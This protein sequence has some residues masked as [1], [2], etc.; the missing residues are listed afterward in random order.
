MKVLIRVCLSM[1]KADL[2]MKSPCAGKKTLEMH[3]SLLDRTADQH[4][5]RKKKHTM[6]LGNK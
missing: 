2:C 6:Q 3:T 1:Y 5:Y 4:Q